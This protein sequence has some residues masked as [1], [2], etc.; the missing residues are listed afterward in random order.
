MGFGG[1][2]GFGRGGMGEH[3]M[4][5]KDNPRSGKVMHPKTLDGKS[6]TRNLKDAD[7]RKA[8]VDW[9]VSKDNYWYSGAF[10][11]RTWGV[12]LGQSFYQPV[13]DIGPQR[14]AV[15][16]TA[17]TRLAGAFAG[18]DHDV[19]ALFRVIMNTQTYQR[20]SKVGKSRG[21]HLYFAHSYPS[22]LR[23]NALYQSLVN[24]VGP[25]DRGGPGGGARMG[26]GFGGRFGFGG[27]E[28]MI[29]TEFSFDP[30]LKNDD[31]EGSIPQSLIL[32]NNTQLNTR[33]KAQ[34]AKL[35]R[36]NDKDDDA[37]EAAYLQALCRKPTAAE[38]KKCLGYV[39]KADSR[40][41]ALE[42][43]LWALINS[44]EFQTRR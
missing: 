9:V 35:V 25:F 39:K 3:R 22:R 34:A 15:H 20:Q 4:P 5:D 19:K 1:G 26:G 30:S 14:E 17:L 23:P 44:T 42:D 12:L 31:V 43:V 29:R 7:R 6:A 10:V 38:L 18:S 24:A 28:G 21:E 2:G 16:G 40:S 36:A 41:E 37:I 27:L 11:N 13:D 32:M 33:I 8:L